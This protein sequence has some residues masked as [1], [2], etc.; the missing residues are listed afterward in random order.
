[1]SLK[2][3]ITVLLFKNTVFVQDSGASHG[4][5]LEWLRQEVSRQLS[6]AAACNNCCVPK[7]NEKNLQNTG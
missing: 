7:V 5:D 2:Q 1:M 4:T 3:T 6:Q